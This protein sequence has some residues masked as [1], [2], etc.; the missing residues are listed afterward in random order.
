MK[1]TSFSRYLWLTPLAYFLLSPI[2][3]IWALLGMT[4]F[5]VPLLLTLL[6]GDKCYC[7]VYCGRGQ[8]FDLLGRRFH[9]SLN[10]PTQPILYSSFFRYAFLIF[11]MA[12]F[13]HVIYYS[14]L[15]FLGISPLREVFSV[16]WFIQIPAE[17]AGTTL[18]P[19]WLAQ[20]SFG[21]FSLMLTSLILGL[22]AML[23]YKPR[24][25]CAFCPMGTMTQALC[26]LRHRRDPF[27]EKKHHE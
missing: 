21:L 3:V 19:A 15:V 4:C 6:R 25:W 26:Q 20:F 2:N 23:L 5:L 1:T 12:Q 24:S 14:Y 22:I 27:L 8:L 13:I 18:F 9:F 10:R 16:L 17:S 11:F 7:N